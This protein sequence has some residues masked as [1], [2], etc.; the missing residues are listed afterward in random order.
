VS[1]TNFPTGALG[2][3]ASFKST[4]TRRVYD[5]PRLSLKEMPYLQLL[6]AASQVPPAASHSALVFGE[7]ACASE[8]AAK[9]TAKASASVVVVAFMSCYPF[10]V[11]PSPDDLRRFSRKTRLIG[12]G[13]SLPDLGESARSSRR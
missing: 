8:P 2:R 6:F 3:P 7:P 11:I 9:R 13:G 12:K 5:P 4:R 10:L 1:Y